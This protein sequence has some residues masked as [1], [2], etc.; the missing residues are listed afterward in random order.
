MLGAFTKK[1]TRH[2]NSE[3]ATHHANRLTKSRSKS[4]KYLHSRAET[5]Y[6]PPTTITI[7]LETIFPLPKEFKDGNGR[8]QD[9]ELLGEWVTRKVY[10]GL[11]GVVDECL[12]DDQ[13][14]VR[15]VRFC[16]CNWGHDANV[17]AGFVRWDTAVGQRGPSQ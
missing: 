10:S 8:T 9:L 6:Q 7:F 13:L 12:D 15:K 14:E 1:R 3:A 4:T 17:W 5:C 16:L 11:F 2:K